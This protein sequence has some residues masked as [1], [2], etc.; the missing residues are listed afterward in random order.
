MG[1]FKR[2][3]RVW[4]SVY[5]YGS[6]TG[7]TGTGDDERVDVDFDVGGQK[8]LAAKYANLQPVAK[9]EEGRATP[10]LSN[11]VIRVPAENQK[12]KGEK[13]M[14]KDHSRIRVEIDDNKLRELVAQGKP[15]SV[16]RMILGV[17]SLSPIKRRMKELGL[18]AA[19]RPGRKPAGEQKS[20]S[21]RRRKLQRNTATVA[22]ET[23]IIQDGKSELL[24]PGA[25]D[26]A[27]APTPLFPSPAPEPRNGQ[28]GRVKVRFIEFEVEGAAG[29]L[30]DSL[31][32]LGAAFA[33]RA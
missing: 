1:E 30:D 9:D 4:H 10:L 17:R 16:M 21:A 31:K 22:V 25:D 20:S 15:L 11:A 6:V 27:L 32:Q 13:T 29:T 19:G 2:N 5:G 14:A 3:Q 26:M 7:G 18:R 12:S 24:K 28:H 33:H 8:R 23:R